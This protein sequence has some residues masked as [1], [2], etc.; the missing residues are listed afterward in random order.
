MPHFIPSP[1]QEDWRPI[2]GYE[3]LYEVSNLGRV[4]RVGR[5][6]Q[7]GKGHGGGVRL[8]RVK[9]PQPAKGGYLKVRLSREGKSR[10][11]LVH[12]LVAA[13]FL[14]PTPEGHEVNH[15]DGIK[16]HCHV[17]NLEFLTRSQN[18]AHALDH[19]LYQHGERHRDARLTADQVI[20][21]RATHAAGGVGYSE[22]AWRFGVHHSTIQDIVKRRKWR[23]L[24]E[25][26]A[27]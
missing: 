7:A 23:R 15:I 24:G 2:A 9:V 13:A 8:G 4:K 25:V 1:E 12:L 16:A 19:D 11:H 20:E 17:G 3:G 26:S 18:M 21:I 27:T 22:L 5:A 6:A 14:G 10:G